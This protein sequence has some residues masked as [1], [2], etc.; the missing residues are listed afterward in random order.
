MCVLSR[1]FKISLMPI[2]VLVLFMSLHKGTTDIPGFFSCLYC[3]GFEVCSAEQTR[4]SREDVEK[5]SAPAL[6]PFILSAGLLPKMTLRT[7]TRLSPGKTGL[8]TTVAFAPNYWTSSLS[9]EST[10]LVN[11][12]MV[13]DVGGYPHLLWLNPSQGLNTDIL[14]IGIIN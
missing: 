4:P 8:Y 10:S 5:W 11:F 12:Q 7:S 13:V 1:G 9:G 3:I 2:S 14:L 6:V